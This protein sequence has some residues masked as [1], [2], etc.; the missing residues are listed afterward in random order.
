[1]DTERREM[2]LQGQGRHC[3]LPRMSS[4]WP[5]TVSSQR[6]A[7]CTVSRER[8]AFTLLDGYFWVQHA[9]EARSPS[10]ST[11]EHRKRVPPIQNITD[12][13]SADVV[14][15]PCLLGQPTRGLR[16]S[17]L[18]LRRVVGMAHESVCQIP[19]VAAS[20]AQ[21]VPN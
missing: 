19:P 1:M 7:S 9:T 21:M 4:C 12:Y 11:S 13:S 3:R 6:P 14:P 18:P 15:K 2:G 20:P 5:E 16:R 10:A 8:L 17:A